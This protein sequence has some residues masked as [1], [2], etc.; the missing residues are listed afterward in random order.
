MND[1]VFKFLV[2]VTVVAMYSAA[3]TWLGFKA[4]K[5]YHECESARLE[6]ED[7]REKR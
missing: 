4:K 2:D 5:A 6:L 3:A 7:I 1:K